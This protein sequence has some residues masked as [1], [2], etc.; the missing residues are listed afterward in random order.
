MARWMVWATL[1]AGVPAM[2]AQ[3][4]TTGGPKFDS[5]SVRPCTPAN[6]AVAELGNCLT[7]SS[8]I[9]GAYAGYDRGHFDPAAPKVRVTG[10]PAWIYSDRYR[11]TGKTGEAGAS[12]LY[13]RATMMQALLEDRFQLKLHR[14]TREIPVYVL[15]AAGDGARLEPH[16][17]GTCIPLGS[18]PGPSSERQRVRICGQYYPSDGNSGVD[19][20]NITLK[21]LCR[22]FSNSRLD[23]PVVDQTGLA[24]SF[25]LH[26]EGTVHQLFA[27]SGP[28]IFTAIQKLGLKL[29]S[30]RGTG[31]F[32]VIDRVDRPS[33]N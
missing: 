7:V 26:F 27:S 33:G 23:R 2:L 29:E 5:A 11:V 16:R 8:L 25:D 31:D 4:A 6:Q 15:S 28:F 14:E 10:G 1:M 3:L 21:E 12:D 18:E 13:A 17:E 9:E 22:D 24:G 19:I 20:F 32:F 30:D